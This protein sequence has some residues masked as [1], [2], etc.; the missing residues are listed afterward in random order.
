MPP[1]ISP[2]QEGAMRMRRIL[3]WKVDETAGEKKP[4]GRIVFLGYMDPGYEHRPTTAPTMTRT[5]RH[6]VRQ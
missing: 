6:I 3:E 4:N 2:P 1:G 5:S